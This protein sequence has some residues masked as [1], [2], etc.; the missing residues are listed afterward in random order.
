M[1]IYCDKIVKGD[2]HQEIIFF[3]IVIHTCI[4]VISNL[5]ERRI[6]GNSFFYFYILAAGA[7]L[8]GSKMARRVGSL[9][10]F[11]FRA[12]GQNHNQGVST[13]VH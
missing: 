11:E 9:E 6:K 3:H 4:F 13:I 5:K 2:L 8:A 7:G 1:L 12:T 10:E